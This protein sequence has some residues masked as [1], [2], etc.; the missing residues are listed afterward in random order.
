MKAIVL[1]QPGSP[2]G[3]RMTD[4][5]TPAPGRGEA[6]VEVRAAGVCHH[7][8]AIMRGQLRRGTKARVV[9][10]HEIAGVVEKIGDDVKNVKP[11]DRVASILTSAC[12]YCVRC[13]E[14]RE[15][16][17]LHGHGL[18]HGVDGGYA[19][20]VIVSAYSLRLVP[21]SVTFEQAAVCACPIGVALRAIRDLATPR[22]G[23]VAVMTG[24]S[25]G[26]GV[27]AVQILRAFGVRVLA[28]TGTAE[29][30]ERLQAVGV[31]EVIFSPDGSFQWEVLALTSEH[32]ADII[33]DT[34]GSA[35]FEA[36]F[37]SL[38][39]YGRLVMLGEVAGGNV[40]FNPANVLFKDARIMGS[41]G[42]SRLDLDQALELV[43]R[44]L[45]K[46][47]V[48]TFPLAAAA[49]VHQMLMDRQMF[50]RAVLIP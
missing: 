5:P 12:G 44:G 7:D 38:A 39:Q 23:D 42:V 35:A 20:Y 27:H 4:L 47:V 19:E 17:C 1:E 13:Q 25:G 16:R 36:A 9:L 40:S 10:G 26:L 2:A 31:D 29:K 11:G 3:L 22:P 6:L 43:R 24:A 8:V 30:I 15:H 41:T 32:G 14:G 46:P 28:V 50:G 18:G 37:A 45:V 48:T 49:K 33:V 34:V 21:E